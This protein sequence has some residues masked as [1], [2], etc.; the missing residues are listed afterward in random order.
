MSGHRFGWAQRRTRE[1]TMPVRDESAQLDLREYLHTL[2]RRWRV[3][4]LAVTM[5]VVIALALSLAQT[6]VYQGSA[7]VLLKPSGAET[8]FATSN[9]TRP[10]PERALQTEVQIIE[11]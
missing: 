10:D 1:G 11:S 4:A 7:E 5:T 3:I 8:L 6:P 2:R 9:G